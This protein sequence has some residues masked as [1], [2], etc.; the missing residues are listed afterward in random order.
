MTHGDNTFLGFIVTMISILVAEGTA[1]LEIPLFYM[2]L[3]QILAWGI[4]ISV[5]LVTIYKFVKHELK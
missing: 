4:G 5:G 2:Q 3:I 1:Q